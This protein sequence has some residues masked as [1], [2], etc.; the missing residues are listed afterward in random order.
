M[1][2]TEDKKAETTVTQTGEQDPGT[3][4]PEGDKPEEK[5]PA[6]V[7]MLEQ[8]ILIMA[9]VIIILLCIICFILGRL[10][11]PAA[12]GKV[13]AA[14]AGAQSSDIQKTD[15]G[16]LGNIK[17]VT[18]KDALTVEDGIVS[19]KQS[20]S[21]AEVSR[22]PASYEAVMNTTWEFDSGMPVSR[23]AFVEN[24]ED[25][26]NTVYYILESNDF[27]GKE[28]YRSKLLKPGDVDYEITLNEALPDGVYDGMVTYF[29]LDD[30]GKEVGTV[31]A[32]VTLK[33]GSN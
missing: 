17:K 12:T 21:K 23:N 24:S 2:E 20:V 6:G 26:A 14:Q 28:L 31:F 8:P 29:L 32:G 27:P 5:K 30:E 3:S 7:L 1:I 19:S 25:N 16:D 10:I 33:A 15:A 4:K 18:A 13:S 22:A 11:A 9:V